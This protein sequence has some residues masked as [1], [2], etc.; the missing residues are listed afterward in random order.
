MSAKVQRYKARS[1]NLSAG[2]RWLRARSGF[3][4]WSNQSKSAAMY[5]GPYG[6]SSSWGWGGGAA[7]MMSPGQANRISCP[8]QK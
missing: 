1:S 5:W 2:Q 4:G 7:S 8:L 6:M 3:W